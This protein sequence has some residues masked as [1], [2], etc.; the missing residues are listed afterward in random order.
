[1]RVS[2]HRIRAWTPS[3]MVA[4]LRLLSQCGAASGLLGKGLTHL[5]G[6]PISRFPR[7][8]LLMDLMQRGL[9]NRSAASKGKKFHR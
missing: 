8:R 2:G 4:A 1:M 6:L 9:D 7:G 3:L 5:G